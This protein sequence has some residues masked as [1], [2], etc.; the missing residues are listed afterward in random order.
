M[1]EKIEAYLPKFIYTTISLNN[2]I[3]IGNENFTITD[4]TLNLLT[5]KANLKLNNVVYLKNHN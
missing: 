2:L 1:L 3:T 5:G 4:I